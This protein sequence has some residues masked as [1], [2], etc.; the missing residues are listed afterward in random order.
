MVKN[1]RMIYILI[2]AINLLYYFTLVPGVSDMDNVNNQGV[3]MPDEQDVFDIERIN[4][5]EGSINRSLKKPVINSSSN[6]SNNTKTTL[7]K[8]YIR[9][10]GANSSL[11]NNLPQELRWEDFKIEK[12]KSFLN[13]VHS[14]LAEDEY[15]IPLVDTCR[16][17]NLNAILLVAITGQEQSF[18]PRSKSNAKIVANNP[19]NV[20]HSWM[21]YNTDIKDSTSIACNTILN[22][23]QNRPQNVDPIQ[24]INRKYARD[25]NWWKGVNKFFKKI[26]SYVHV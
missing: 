26:R 21:E 4:L 5:A 7:G 3:V 11:A 2:I 23:S 1:I 25:Q 22:L 16:R 24:W 19:F 18:V 14:I 20:Y 12:M 13:S 6:E 9:G 15:L 10:N 17:K 8:M